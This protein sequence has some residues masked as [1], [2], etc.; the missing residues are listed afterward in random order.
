LTQGITTALIN[1][2]GGGAADLRPEVAAIEKNV[3]GI[4]VIPQIGHN[5]VRPHAYSKG[6]DYVFVNGKAAIAGGKLEPERFG[7]I[8]LRGG[9]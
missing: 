2:D 3:A 4:N 5:A 7:R 1:P 8:I 6:M 9:N